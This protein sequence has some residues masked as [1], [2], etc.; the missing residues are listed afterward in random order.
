M[1]H[2]AE[3]ALQALMRLTPDEL[4]DM[5]KEMEITRLTALL[6]FGMSILNEA[7]FQA[8]DDIQRLN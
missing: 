8:Y 6:T 4:M 7:M 5:F 2:K 3:I 1:N